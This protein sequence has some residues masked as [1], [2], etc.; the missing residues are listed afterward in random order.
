[1]HKRR[2]HPDPDMSSSS[3]SET[4]N[5][6]HI[7]CVSDKPNEHSDL[8]NDNPISVGGFDVHTANTPAT[9]TIADI[10]ND[11]APIRFCVCDLVSLSV[12][13]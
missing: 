7:D 1:M 12:T 11:D 6:D 3:S 5:C 8:S 2:A 10:D 9:I 13:H 4:N